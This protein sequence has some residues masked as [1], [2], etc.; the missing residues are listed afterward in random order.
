VADYGVGHLSTAVVSKET[1]HQ[2]V[3][4][5]CFGVFSG[6]SATGASC[7]LQVLRLA[8]GAGKSYIVWQEIFDNGIRIRPDA[9]VH[10][11]PCSEA[12][13]GRDLSLQYRMPSLWRG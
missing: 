13:C 8:S 2:S 9:V 7:W 5:Q 12:A 3:G 10:V 1:F 4:V 6:P 11:R